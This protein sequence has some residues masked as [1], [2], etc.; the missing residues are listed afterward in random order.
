MPSTSTTTTTYLR[1][2]SGIW[3]KLVFERVEYKVKQ[4]VE[5]EERDSGAVIEDILPTIIHQRVNDQQQRIL[6]YSHL[7]S[8]PFS[9]N[10]EQ[11]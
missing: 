9:V 3:M 8:F 2:F 10:K 5:Q 4:E 11:Q 6:S 7:P 1:H